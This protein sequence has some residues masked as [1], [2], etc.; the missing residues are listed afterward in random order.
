MVDRLDGGG[1]H[2]GQSAERRGCGEHAQHSQV[3]VVGGAREKLVDRGVDGADGDVL[4]QKEEDGE[5]DRGQRR[6]QPKLERQRE[7]RQGLERKL[8]CFVSTG[9][10]L[11]I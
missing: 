7:E 9:L 2:P 3:E 1:T 10:W 5:E 4:V 6:E 8:L 11:V